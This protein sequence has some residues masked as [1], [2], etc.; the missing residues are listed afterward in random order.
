MGKQARWAY[1]V[2]AVLIGLV[3]LLYALHPGVFVV[4]FP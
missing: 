4:S 3:L 1:L 2:G